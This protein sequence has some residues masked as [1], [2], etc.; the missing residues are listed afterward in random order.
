[1]ALQ[2]GT[3]VVAR[4]LSLPAKLGGALLR[5]SPELS[6]A[7]ISKPGAPGATE[8]QVDGS[9]WWLDSRY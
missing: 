2:Y 5:L 3:I 7:L 8:S 1:M 9:F 6:L 4:D